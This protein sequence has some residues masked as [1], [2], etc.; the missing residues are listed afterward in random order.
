MT[1]SRS[2]T[3]DA[4][5][6][7]AGSWH[8]VVSRIDKTR[9]CT[10]IPP[11]WQH[12]HFS[13]HSIGATQ[14]THRNGRKGMNYCDDSIAATAVPTVF[15][16]RSTTATMYRH[17]QREPM[18]YRYSTRRLVSSIIGVSILTYSG[19]Q[20]HY[21][22]AVADERRILLSTMYIRSLSKA[23]ILSYRTDLTHPQLD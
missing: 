23:Y 9:H 21:R 2:M 8:A 10:H 20:P 7:C 6:V 19:C 5:L 12:H 13:L 3:N 4:V 17:R 16:S 11:E 1:D 18:H 22:D 14:L 15:T